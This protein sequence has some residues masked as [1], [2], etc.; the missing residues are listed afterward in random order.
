MEKI[1][2]YMNRHFIILL[3]SVLSFYPLQAKKNNTTTISYTLPKTIISINIESVE[4]EII[5]S[6]YSRYGKSLL[7]IEL[8]EKD[9]TCFSISKIA[10]NSYI[11]PDYSTTRPITLTEQEKL[12]L[13][14]LKK[15]GFIYEHSP[16]IKIAT[17]LLPVK[18]PDP[19]PRVKTSYENA[20]KAASQ[21]IR[22][23]EDRYNIVTG[24]TDATYSGEAMGAA[25]NELH[26]AENELLSLFLPSTK[27]Y[28]YTHTFDFVPSSE[29]TR[30]E[31]FCFSESLGILPAGS[32]E[33]IPYYLEISVEEIADS[34]YTDT[35]SK[36]ENA[37]TYR[38]PA[39]CTVK[40]YCYEHVV[41]HL[42]VPIFQLGSNETIIL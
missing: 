34:S 24:N 11:E 39:I 21:I 28:T 20:R 27:T 7:G 18:N 5:T 17:T 16:Q 41:C 1:L 42:R 8:P 33:G 6:P 14:R 4:N 31:A 3:I 26:N 2:I 22:Y 25:L 32:P 40:V 12:E 23:R 19:S 37:L 10:I 35:E 13:G 36:E 38:V 29:C 30:L 15:E 9:S